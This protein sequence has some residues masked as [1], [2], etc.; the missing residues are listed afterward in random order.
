M[1]AISGNRG[2]EALATISV[3]RNPKNFS[4]VTTLNYSRNRNTVL[5]LDPQQKRYLLASTRIGDV[6]ADEGTRLVKCL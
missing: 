2:I 1:P 3:L 4:W 6:R 5:E